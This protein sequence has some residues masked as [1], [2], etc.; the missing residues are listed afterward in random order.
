[1]FFLP[2]RQHME[3]L[4]LPEAKKHTGTHVLVALARL[5]IAIQTA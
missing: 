3:T 4:L 1:M 5:L 2:S